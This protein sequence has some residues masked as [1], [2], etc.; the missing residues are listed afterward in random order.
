[1]VSILLFMQIIHAIVLSYDDL[2]ACV[3]VCCSVYVDN[4]RTMCT[5]I[6][7]CSVDE[8]KVKKMLFTTSK[9]KS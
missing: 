8:I 7:T 4:G 1:M 6:S 5:F 9:P 2:T 3:G